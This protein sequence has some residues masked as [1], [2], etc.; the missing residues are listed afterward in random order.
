MN[1]MVVT[2]LESKFNVFDL[3][4]Q[5]PTKGFASLTEK[6]LTE[7]AGFSVVVITALDSREIAPYMV[8]RIEHIPSA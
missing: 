1:K 8:H 7:A 3:R 6:V 5:H 4:T 2:S